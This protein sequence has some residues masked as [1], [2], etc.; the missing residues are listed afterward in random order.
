M[1]ISKLTAGALTLLLCFAPDKFAL[2]EPKGGASLETII[3]G[4]FF[5]NNG[6]QQTLRE[7]IDAAIKLGLIENSATTWP[8][9]GVPFS[10]EI[11]LEVF[12]ED[13]H[14][15]DTLFVNQTG[16]VHMIFSSNFPVVLGV[17]HFQIKSSPGPGTQYLTLRVDDVTFNPVVSFMDFKVFNPEQQN[18]TSPDTMLMVVLDKTFANG[19]VGQD[20]DIGYFE[21]TP[22][23]QGT[24]SLDTTVNVRSLDP[25]LFVL[26]SAGFPI[27]TVRD[28]LDFSF[29]DIAVVCA[30]ASSHDFS[31]VDCDGI[32]NVFDNCPSSFNPNQEEF[33]T[34]AGAGNACFMPQYLTPMIVVAREALGGNPDSIGT[35]PQVNLRVRD[36]DGFAIGY[37]SINIFTNDIGDSASY[38]QLNG[39]DSIVINNPKS[40]VYIIEAFAQLLPD[41]ASE[42]RTQ[43]A[44]YTI[45]V[46]ADGTI[47]TVFGAFVNPITSP[48]IPPSV[49]IFAMERNIIDTLDFPAIPFLIGSADGNNKINIADITYLIARIFADGP[50]PVPYE[51][52]GDANCNQKV[53]IAD[54]TFLIARIFAGGAAPGCI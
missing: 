53:N 6:G 19:V 13:G 7:R 32:L 35:D 30:G 2:S 51:A 24:L 45:G 27:V 4:H 47:E 22:T 36:P 44:F 9:S 23:L 43:A 15:K 20:L 11:R 37:D 10:G 29:S 33:D 1:S 5:N 28:S 54:I 50:A 38:F 41:P 8:S 34:T 46:R 42:T 3:T 48:P 18:G 40:G 17:A 21:I 25:S 39:S 12:A 49:S 52:A 14:G 31:D 16:R 26:G